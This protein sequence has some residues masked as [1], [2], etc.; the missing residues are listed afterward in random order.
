M[1]IKYKISGCRAHYYLL[2]FVFAF[3]NCAIA[4][5][6]IP[7]KSKQSKLG[8]LADYYSRSVPGEFENSQN[9]QIVK[10]A[11]IDVENLKGSKIVTD[12]KKVFLKTA[13]FEMTYQFALYDTILMIE[14]VT[15]FEVEVPG[16]YHWFIFDV[17][18]NGKADPEVDKSYASYSYKTLSKQYLYDETSSFSYNHFP[19]SASFNYSGDIKSMCYNIPVN[20][21]TTQDTISFLLWA[22]VRTSWT[23]DFSK[24]FKIPLPENLK[25]FGTVFTKDVTEITQTSCSA[26]GIVRSNGNYLASETGIIWSNNEYMSLEYNLGK[27][28]NKSGSDEFMVEINGLRSNTKYSY[29][30]YAITDDITF[31]GNAV[32]FRTEIDTSE[33]TSLDMN[34]LI[35]NSGRNVIALVSEEDFKLWCNGFSSLES[36]FLP[37]YSKIKDDFDFAFLIPNIDERISGSN[38]AGYSLKVSNSVM[39]IGLPLYDYSAAYGSSGRLKSFIRLPKRSSLKN[40]PSLHELMHNWANYLIDSRALYPGSTSPGSLIEYKFGAQHGSHWGISSAGGQL[41]G[42]DLLKTDVDGEN[43]KYQGNLSYHPYWFQ[44]ANGGN[45]IPFSNLELYLMGLISPEE[46]T[47]VKFFY[48]LHAKNETEFFNEGKFYSDSVV[49]FNAEDIIRTAGGP[50][51]PDYKNSQKEYKAL[52]VLVSPAMPTSDEI[53]D[54][55]NYSSW[56]GFPGSDGDNGYFN[57]YEAT[58]GKATLITGDYLKSLKPNAAPIITITSPT[59]GTKYDKDIQLIYTISDTDFDKATYRID[60]GTKISASQNG[61]I[62]LTLTDG[63]HKIVIEATDK[64]PQTSKDSVSFEIKKATAI[65]GTSFTE[66]IRVYPIPVKD[67]LNIEYKFNTEQKIQREL[68]DMNGRL[69]Y[70]DWVEI[71]GEQTDKLDMSKYSSGIYLLKQVMEKGVKRDKIFKR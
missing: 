25:N 61:T 21:I 31:Y 18:N 2:I 68:Y 51:I 5:T 7:S 58:Y 52:I 34:L 53:Q 50:R 46:L 37:L 45:S 39:G 67:F 23:F 13:D 57:F 44:N 20:E 32:S 30:A 35:S 62:P 26:G 49:T 3:F 41:G 43:N 14:F 11:Q 69:L 56:L 70:N 65:D 55:D 71:T 64:K 33:F 29:R 10:E 59:E 28:I 38:V 40:G 47:P 60:N 15:T 1:R 17:N 8:P 63:I 19:S 9:N 16:N 66:G 42:F 22:P 6:Q 36:I 27:V 24:A 48:K 4:Q 54:L 12:S